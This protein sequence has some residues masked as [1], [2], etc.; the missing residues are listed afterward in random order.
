MRKWMGL[1]MVGFFL[2][3]LAGA[4]IALLATPVTGEKAR[5]FVRE[6]ALRLANGNGSVVRVKVKDAIE[7]TKSKA[8]ETAKKVR[9]KI[10]SRAS[11][12]ASRV[13]TADDPGR[14]GDIGIEEP[15]TP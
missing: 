8:R 5:D 2:G 15:N 14:F 10:A 13:G 11:S 4:G 9:A 6:K 3:G 7:E 12:G 1:N